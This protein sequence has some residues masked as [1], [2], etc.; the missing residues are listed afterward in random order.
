MAVVAPAPRDGGR[1]RA[2]EATIR[3]PIREV[4]AMI[5]IGRRRLR[6]GSSALGFGTALRCGPSEGVMTEAERR[7]NRYYR[8]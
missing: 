1:G 7:A 6:E 3:D 2:R 5:R 4:F 8:V